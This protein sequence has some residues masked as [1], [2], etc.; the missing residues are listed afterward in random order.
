MD[1]TLAQLALHIGGT[2]HGGGADCPVTGVAGVDSVGAGEVTFVM[3]ERYLD[4]AETS[5]ALAIIAP[6]TITSAVKPFIHVEDPRAAFARA[7]GLFDWRRLPLSGIH[8]SAVVAQSAGIHAHASIGAHVTVGEFSVI[9]DGAVIFP[10]VVIGD[11]VEIGAGTIINANATIYARVTLGQR[12]IVH[13]GAIIG[14][15]GM[16]YQPTADG[17]VK[18]PHLGTV[19]VEDDVEIGANTTIDRATTGETVIGAGTKIDN[20]VQI[21]HNVKI[22]PRCMILAQVGISGSCVIDEGVI[23]G[24]QAGLRDHLH[25]HAGAIVIAQSGISRDIKPGVVVSGTPAQPH[26][27]ELRAQAGYRRLP[28]IVDQLKKLEA[29]LAALEKGAE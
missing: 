20:L 7:L 8:P 1:I 9:G 17:W 25:I 18:L 2:L 19:I 3:N 4:A 14:S 12:V 5:P 26:D 11:H 10:N 6:P 23:L 29:R 16:G 13:S 22:G 24:G 15:D 28:R 21:A 27:E